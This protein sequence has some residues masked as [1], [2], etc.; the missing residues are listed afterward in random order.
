M[1]QGDAERGYQGQVGTEGS[2][3]NES[4]LL[5]RQPD[6]TCQSFRVTKT[7]YQSYFCCKKSAFLCESTTMFC[8]EVLDAYA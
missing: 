5:D 1:R 3:E 8:R 6:P 4:K 7:V 2:G